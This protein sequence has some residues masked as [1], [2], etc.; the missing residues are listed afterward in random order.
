M[1]REQASKGIRSEWECQPGRI[2]WGMHSITMLCLLLVVISG[3]SLAAQQTGD[4]V[5]RGVLRDAGG[6]PIAA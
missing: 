4:V 1:A 3:V 6:A 2:A 5:W